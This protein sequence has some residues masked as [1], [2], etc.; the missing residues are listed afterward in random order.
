M[1]LASLWFERWVDGNFD[2]I[3]MEL[4]YD[5]YFFDIW[6]ILGWCTWAWVIFFGCNKN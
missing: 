6:V 5:E 2:S 1:K 4:V 3:F